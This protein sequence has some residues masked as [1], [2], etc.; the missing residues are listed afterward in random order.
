MGLMEVFIRVL[1][2]Q[3]KGQNAPIPAVLGD[4]E[5]CNELCIETVQRC[6]CGAQK[7]A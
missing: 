7:M 3:P 4:P 2:W 1:L 5:L 6:G